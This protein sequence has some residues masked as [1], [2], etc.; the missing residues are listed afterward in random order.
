MGRT[1][2][3]V[4]LLI[5]GTSGVGSAQGSIP[6]T[7]NV[8]DA[9]TVYHGNVSG[10]GNSDTVSSID[11]KA[12]AWTS[13][14][15]DGQIYGEPLIFSGRIFVATEN[16]TVYAL[17][18]AHGNVVWSSHIGPPVPASSL[19]CGNISPT[20]GITGTPVIDQAKSELFVVA[21]EVIDGKPAH[22]LVGLS[23]A[24]GRTQMTERVDPPG[25][26]PAALLQRTGLTLDAGQVIFGL[27]GNY[28]DCAT[29]RGR[30]E[31]VNE[32]GGAPVVF[33]IDAAAG[34]S[35]G[36]VWMGG[37][38]P[39]V[40]DSGNVWVSVGN[41]SVTSHGRSFDDSDSVL[42]L[43]SSLSLLAYF[44]PSN[45]PENNANDLDMSTAPA[46][47]SDGHVV[48]SGKSGVVY[49]LNTSDPGGVGGQ[50]AS[51]ASGCSQDID[52]GSAV[53][54]TTVFLPC[55]SGTIAVQAAQSPAALHLVWASSVG[56]GPPIVAAG[57]IW[58]IDPHGTLYGLNAN[59]GKVQQQASIGVPANHFPTP[60]V[61]A[62]FL[63]APAADR[64]V[65]FVASTATA[66]TSTTATNT[67]A[68]S[69]TAT[70][71]ASTP[72]TIPRSAAQ[73]STGKTASSPLFLVA[74]L[75]VLSVA[76]A[77]G[78]VWLI[79]R[80]RAGSVRE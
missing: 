73:N 32:S 14:A 67:A 20:V 40:D 3:W 51:L 70:T 66:A 1:F 2:S 61:G 10:S 71:P 43:S 11:T 52:G 54:G 36:A 55:G 65:A 12:P 60:S 35:Q 5:L 27:G 72:T 47:L 7:S 38:A 21:D 39:T 56:G 33:T 75:G 48:A 49:L 29:Y 64:L 45:W 76:L 31:A 24:T 19:P 74:T 63:V 78:G 68:A 59:T 41:G 4:T 13:P 9:W 34:D 53:I 77:G 23:T 50:V 25:A 37:A 69:T 6:P 16:D 80:R 17:S 62:G 58:T 22:M 18:S 15:L 8:A 46:L 42:K 26:D 30:V 57:L 28:G 79:R 44:A